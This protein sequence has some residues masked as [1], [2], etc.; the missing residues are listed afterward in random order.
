VDLELHQLELR[1]ADL[2]ICDIARLRQLAL[3]VEEI[4]QQVP[5]VVVQDGERIV[6]IDGYLRVEALRRLKRDTV[7]A[8]P[9][10]LGE[11]EALIQRHHLA[12]SGRS[13]L[14]EGWLLSHLAHE[15][16]LGQ[17]DLARRFCRSTSW[18]SRRIALVGELS[19]EIQG[20]VR[21]GAVPAH[22][23]MKYLVPLARANRRHCDALVAA[24]GNTRLSERD[25]GALYAGY[26]RADHEGRARLVS[27]PHLFLKALREAG[28]V[29][30]PSSA[31]ETATALVKDLSTVSATCWRAYKRVG[32]SVLDVEST[33][34]R[35]HLGAAWRAAES[36][37]FALR[38]AMTEAWPDAGSDDTKRDSS[39]A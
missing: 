4:G 10:L 34:G 17:D 36:A 3:S 8:T 6:L 28:S 22:A 9:W 19:A 12:A 1:H 5:V 24:L 2:R 33:Y 30:E 23:A 15:R 20:R 25:V 14:E 16:G 39:A 27:D 32:Q 29:A 26:R 11:A 13:A 31:E 7:A 38:E 21:A 18:V 37:F 35:T